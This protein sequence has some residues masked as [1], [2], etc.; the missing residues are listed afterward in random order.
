MDF[1]YADRADTQLLNVI[2]WK[3]AMG[4]QP[5]PYW[6]LMK[7]KSTRKDDDD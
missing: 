5:I 3:D 4:G 2:L 1:T 6:L 7:H